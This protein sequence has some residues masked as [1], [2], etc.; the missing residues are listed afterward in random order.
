MK[1]KPNPNPSL[2]LTLSLTLT[3][4]AEMEPD[5]IEELRE[6]VAEELTAFSSLLDRHNPSL[7][8]HEALEHKGRHLLT[9]A[10][11]T[12]HQI[13]NLNMQWPRRET[14][15]PRSTT[16]RTDLVLGGSSAGS[17]RAWQ[18]GLYT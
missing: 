2:I 18:V 12:V 16:D 11:R 9:T 15:A 7:S 10:S 8:S 4:W 6:A 17:F 14:S 13:Q 1:L 5:D 3:G